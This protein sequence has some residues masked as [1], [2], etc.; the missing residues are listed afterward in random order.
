M[1]SAAQTFVYL[2]YMTHGCESGVI[3]LGIGLSRDMAASLTCL[4]S[5]NPNG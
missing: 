3:D 2:L 4:K 5:L 1:L